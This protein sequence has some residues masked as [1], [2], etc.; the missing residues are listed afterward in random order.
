MQHSIQ[1]P[2]SLQYTYLRQQ[3]VH[4]VTENAAKAGPRIACRGFVYDLKI[5]SFRLY[6]PEF[7]RWSKEG[8]LEQPTPSTRS[9]RSLRRLA[10]FSF[11]FKSSCR[12]PC[13]ILRTGRFEN[14]CF[15]VSLWPSHRL[16]ACN[17]TKLSKARASLASEQKSPAMKN[18]L[19]C[20]PS[21]KASSSAVA[22]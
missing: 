20:S 9:M 4:S 18:A 22:S 11:A 2:P 13:A 14:A 12:H 17:Q 15:G 10:F 19:P 7:S 6:V 3:A 1:A 5:L 8:Y 21:S 16:V